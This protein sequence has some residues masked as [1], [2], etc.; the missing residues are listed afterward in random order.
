MDMDEEN[1]GEDVK[2]RKENDVTPKRSRGGKKRIPCLWRV[3]KT[4]VLRSLYSLPFPFPRRRKK[5]RIW[6]K[7]VVRW[8]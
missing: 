3:K 2:T 6:R 8:L 1:K 5:R 7:E 4:W